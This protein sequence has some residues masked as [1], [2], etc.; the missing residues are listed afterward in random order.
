MV[1]C[2]W[3]TACVACYGHTIQNIP[4]LDRSDS[5]AELGS[6][7]IRLRDRPGTL[8]AVVSFAACWFE[9]GTAIPSRTYPFSSDQGTQTGLGSTSTRL[10][11]RP[12]TLSAVVSFAACWF[13]GWWNA[14]SNVGKQLVQH[15]TAI[16]S[17]TYPFSSDQGSQTGLGSTSTRLSDRPGT[18]SAVVSFAGLRVQSGW[19]NANS[20]ELEK[21]HLDLAV[22]AV[23]CVALVCWRA[24]MRLPSQQKA[25]AGRQRQHAVV[26]G[27]QMDRPGTLSAVVSFAACW[28]EEL[29]KL[30]L[31]L[32][33]LAVYCVALS[34][35]VQ[36]VVSAAYGMYRDRP[37][38][39]SA[40]V[41]FAAC[42]FEVG[43]QLVQHAAAIPS[44]TY[45]FSTD[46]IVKLNWAQLNIPLLDRSDSQAELGSNSIRLS[47]PLGT[48][49]AVVSF[50]ACWFEGWWNANSNELEKLHL[51]LAV[52][53]VY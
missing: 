1:S 34:G 52:L 46:Q 51:D 45:P 4:L 47:D 28:F 33:V 49:S 48:L 35:A 43:K 18:L 42:W 3:K 7:S 30:H 15:A 44:R 32:A 9:A 20:N 5:Q 2:S 12:G 14:N 21:L 23:Y 17:R 27:E 41:S 25:N 29:E 16:P 37:G 13:E 22:L 24:P 36:A 50:A 26:C 40:V 53:A 31:D 6:T 19:W 38:T 11:D 8:S 10:S 39:L